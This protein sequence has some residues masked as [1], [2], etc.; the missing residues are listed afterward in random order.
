[1]YGTPLFFSLDVTVQY[2][3]LLVH[4][5][6]TKVCFLHLFT[7]FK[8][9]NYSLLLLYMHRSSRPR[10]GQPSTARAR[11]WASYAPLLALILAPSS[12][13]ELPE[14]YIHHDKQVN[15][16]WCSGERTKN[17]E[18][19]GRTDASACRGETDRPVLSKTKR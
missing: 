3:A 12:I 15:I 18:Q 4:L 10:A 5:C 1:M 19:Y 17:K 6:T 13:R 11:A 9:D 8:D 16:Q 2:I 7:F 14:R